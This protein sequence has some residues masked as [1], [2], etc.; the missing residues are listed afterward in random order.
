[1]AN[2]DNTFLWLTPKLGA[3]RRLGSTKCIGDMAASELDERLQ[4]YVGRGAIQKIG[5][6]LIDIQQAVWAPANVIQT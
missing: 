1:M 3:Q 6:F 4:A 2:P 5:A